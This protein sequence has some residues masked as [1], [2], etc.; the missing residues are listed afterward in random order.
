[1]PD[2]ER[3]TSDKNVFRVVALCITAMF[4]IEIG[5]YMQRA[6][7]TRVLED[8]V[9]RGYFASLKPRSGVGVRWEPGIPEEDVSLLFFP[10]SGMFMFDLGVFGMVLMVVV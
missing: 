3:G 2:T 6:P 4:L 1:M 8:I 5:D 9:C 10:I 7:W